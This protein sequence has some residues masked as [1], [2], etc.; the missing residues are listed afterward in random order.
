VKKN[1]NIL[2]IR[3]FSLEKSPAN[4][5]RDWCMANLSGHTCGLLGQEIAEEL[6]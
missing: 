5:R 6:M 1:G 4:T 3:M 2:D